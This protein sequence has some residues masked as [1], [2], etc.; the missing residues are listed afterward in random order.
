MD[1]SI[2]LLDFVLH[3]FDEGHFPGWISRVLSLNTLFEDGTKVM[4]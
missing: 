2:P 4:I 1:S 3:D